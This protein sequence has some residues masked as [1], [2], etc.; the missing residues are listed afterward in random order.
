MN[1]ELLRIANALFYLDKR[2]CVCMYIYIYT[3]TPRLYTIVLLHHMCM[4][5]YLYTHITVYI[6]NNTSQNRPILIGPF[7]EVVNLES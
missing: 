5:M 1:K 2:R 7:M 3:Y 6:Y 4:Y